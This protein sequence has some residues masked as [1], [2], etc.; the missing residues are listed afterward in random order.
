MY[1]YFQKHCY[2]DK[3]Q[4]LSDLKSRD[5]EKMKICLFLHLFLLIVQ[6]IN[7]IYVKKER[8]VL[9]KKKFSLLNVNDKRSKKEIMSRVFLKR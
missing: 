7:H 1:V 5:K 2:H 9:L 8:H 4:W 3:N 6:G